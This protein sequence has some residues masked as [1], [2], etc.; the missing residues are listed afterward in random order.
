M[1]SRNVLVSGASVAGPSVAYW[2]AR[3]GFRVTVVETAAAIR[4][5]GYAVD[6]R[7]AAVE[8][9]SR[10][11][12]LQD[13][14]SASTQMGDM[15]NVDS[16]DRRLATLPAEIFG[17]EIEVLRGDLSQILYEHTK[18]GVE[19]VFGDSIAALI[20]DASGVQVTF[21]SGRSRRFD[22]VIGADGLHSNT[23][24]LAFGRES[25]F[26]EFLGYYLSIFTVPNKLNLDYTGHIYKTPGRIAAMYSARGNTQAK[27]FFAFSSPMLSYDHRDIAEQKKLLTQAYVG[28]TGWEVPWLLGELT[29]TPDF[30]FDSTSQVHLDR[31]S[32]GRVVLLGDAAYCASPLSGQGTGLAIV[33]AYVLAGELAAANGDHVAGFDRYE[34]QM[35][36]YVAACQ[37]LAVS[38]GPQLVPP[39]PF[40]NWMINQSLRIL[41]YT[42]WKGAITAPPRKAANAIELKTYETAAV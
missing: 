6:L 19:Y 42:P 4:D 16:A 31:Y 25:D 14:R 18:A 29:Q 20:E 9:A 26:T 10:M 38:A 23:R 15:W 41:P 27:A 8:V 40:Q 24:R 34:R 13:I 5:G 21:E 37:K 12:V 11:G 28:E 1:D 33:G 2:L 39:N 35:R 30:Y 3:H 36:G 22:L 32:R 17:G 7:A